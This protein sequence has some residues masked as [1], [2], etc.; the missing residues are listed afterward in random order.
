MSSRRKFLAAGLAACCGEWFLRMPARADS[1]ALREKLTALIQPAIAAGGFPG[2][3]VQFGN[4]REVTFE[5][6]WGRRQVEPV[7]E[8]MT[9]DTIFDLASLTKPIATATSVM[10]LAQTGRLSVDAT[11]ATYWPEFGVQGK[12]VLTLRDLL[13]H[14]SGLI[15]DNPIGDYQHG[16]EEALARIAG[17]KLVAA[18]RQKMIY[19]DVNFIV[20]GEIVARVAGT[21]LHEYFRAEV[22]GPLGLRDTGF[23]PDEA[24]IPRIA[25]T[26][27]LRGTWLRGRVHDPRAAGLGGVAGHAGLFGSSHDL[28]IYS[29]SLL[30][31]LQQEETGL[32]NAAT[33]RAMIAPQR[34][35][36]GRTDETGENQYAVRGLG[37]DIRSGFS[38]NRPANASETSFGHTGF[39]GTSIWLDPEQDY[40]ALLLAN[41][42]H[43]QGKG[44]I[45][46]LSGQIGGF[47]KP[48]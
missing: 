23:L 38:R 30:R 4:S 29:R 27:K 48:M 45:H 15:A 2:C 12:D 19:S 9:T 31:T 43:P 20:L 3:V 33:A 22:A 34:V 18:P 36:T 46:P 32:L 21:P 37:W 42:L 17:L 28:G 25:P 35:P 39:T 24:L 14:R 6:A 8:A 47:A 26:E 16:R 7:S 41:R 13:C 1:Q 40:Y 5:Q 44:S 10:V 11:V